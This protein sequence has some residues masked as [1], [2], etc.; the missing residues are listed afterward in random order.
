MLVSFEMKEKCLHDQ[1][2]YHPFM[3]NSFFGKRGR[4]SNFSNFLNID[5]IIGIRHDLIVRIITIS[6]GKAIKSQISLK[7]APKSLATIFVQVGL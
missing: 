3:Y 7:F 1:D 5:E 2:F 6:Y 4:C